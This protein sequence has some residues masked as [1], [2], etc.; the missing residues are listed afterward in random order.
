MVQ[1]TNILNSFIQRYLPNPF[2]IAVFLLVL[3]TVSALSIT[4]TPPTVIITSFTSGFWS[5]LGFTM[6]LSIVLITSATIANSSLFKKPFQKLAALPKNPTQAAFYVAFLTSLIGLI[7]WGIALVIG[8][9]FAKEVAR[10][11]KGSHY[12]LLIAASYIGFTLWSSGL[13]SSIPLILNTPGNPLEASVGII[14]LTETI[15]TKYNLIIT[16]GLL[17]TYAL[18]SKMMVPKSG[19]VITAPDQLN[20]A[21][22]IINTDE[23]PN[24]TTPAE[25]LEASRIISLIA[26][27]FSLT[28]FIYTMTTQGINALNLNT[29]NMLTLS[30]GL[31]IYPNVKSYLDAATDTVKTVAPII[32]L[33]PFYGAAQTMIA[34][35][36]LGEELTFFFASIA[37]KDTLPLLTYLSA[38]LLNLFIPAA[39]GQIVIQGPIF[40]PLAKDLGVNE[41]LIAMAITYG[42]TWTNLLQPFWALPALGL[43]GLGVRDIMGYCILAMLASGLV[44]AILLTF[45]PFIV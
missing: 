39:G 44:T 13:S 7:N 25:K 34:A 38:G 30:I 22:D 32:L 9:I 36:G 41:G 45:L 21:I 29:I 27:I 8:I 2:V 11:V 19:N 5:L 17:L 35:S 28:S 1:I 23:T 10:Q 43:A 31:F 15:F 3:I 26:A 4:Q 14:P 37:T 20:E 33:Y 24:T 42:D 18:I 40:I 12:P 16:F 6:Q